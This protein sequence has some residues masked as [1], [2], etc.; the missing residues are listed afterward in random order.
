MWIKEGSIIPLLHNSKE[1][2]L[3]RAIDNDVDLGVYSS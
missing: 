1:L 2:S 3:L